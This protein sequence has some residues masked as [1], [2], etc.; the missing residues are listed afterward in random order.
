M[1]LSLASG[2]LAWM[3][4]LRKA[5][6]SNPDDSIT[7]L[8]LVDSGTETL[9]GSLVLAELEID[10]ESENAQDEIFDDLEFLVGMTEED[11]QLELSTSAKKES[12]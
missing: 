3:W 9:E 7:L 12:S 8:S 4:R 11:W 2:A 10:Q 1:G 6:T 5:A